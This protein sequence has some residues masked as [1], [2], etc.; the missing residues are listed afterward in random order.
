MAHHRHATGDEIG[1]GF[2]HRRPAL[3]LD[4]LG[5][6]LLH[7]PDGVGVGL[8][9]PAFVGAE[10]HVDDH[11]RPARPAHHRL[12]VQDHHLQG[13][14]DG[15]VQAVDHHAD[16]V[17][18]QQDV[19][20]LVQHLGHRGGIGGQHHDG[21]LALEGGDVRRGEALDLFLALRRHLEL[22]QRPCRHQHDREQDQGRAHPHHLAA[23]RQVGQDT[24]LSNG[25]HAL[26]DL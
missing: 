13:D 12:A 23:Q 5:A 26:G 9:L 4:G 16:G 8:L 7:H 17:A 22:L 10:G 11:H 1:D 14:A 21:R 15:V 19:A 2:G 25:L 20:R 3:D 18:N 24:Q 6:G